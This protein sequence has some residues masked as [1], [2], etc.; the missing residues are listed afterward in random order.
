M[1]QIKQSRPHREVEKVDEDQ[2]HQQ[3]RA[4]LYN[5]DHRY[6]SRYDEHQQPHHAE[7]SEYRSRPNDR[8][9]DH[10]Y[11]DKEYNDQYYDKRYNDQYY[12]KRY[13]DQYYDKEYN[14]QYY[15]E[16]YNGQY[17]DKE[18]NDQY[19]EEQHDDH[20][21]NAPRELRLVKLVSDALPSHQ[22]IAIVEGRDGGISIG[23]DRCFTPRIRCPTME[24]S[25][26]HA[27]IFRLD[28]GDGGR[29]S[30]WAESVFAVADTGSTHGTY[31]LLDAPTNITPDSL[32]PI[33]AYQRLSPPKKAS[34]PNTLRHL[35]LLRVGQ[36]VFQAH[37]HDGW[38]S[39]QDC[40]VD[41]NGKNKIPLLA[42]EK[43]DNKLAPTKE[44]VAK[45][46]ES[47]ATEVKVTPRQAMR[48]LKSRHLGDATT[49]QLV[50]S[51]T[52][53]YVDRAAA[54]RARGGV[55]AITPTPSA[56]AVHSV[57]ILPSNAAASTTAKSEP[58]AA[59]DASNRGFKMFAS[60][61]SKSG[62]GAA[63]LANGRQ[64]PILARGVEGRAGL[65]SKRLLDVQEI[66]S[67]SYDQSPASIR[68]RQRRR[69][70]EA[71]ST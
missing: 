47:K 24:V 19:Y 70:E 37:L 59:L 71:S 8:Y 18:H 43:K 42:E 4:R 56:A 20:N 57:P 49:G 38:T 61:S 58:A 66:A 40:T 50:E 32:P 2:R 14:D 22:T 64:D 17:Y 31:L 55:Q 28:Q 3:E 10:D 6:Y 54:R 12:D 68:E 35:S 45:K 48:E 65:G 27:N 9:G 63:K 46:S 36:T 26:H 60:M 16:E 11:Y 33:T 34:A 29:N 69:F 44:G 23:R 41:E 13:N 5:D 25:K 67:Q 52:S 7:Y 30:R 39:C 21:Q 1:D 62:G 53:Q 51:S 15:D